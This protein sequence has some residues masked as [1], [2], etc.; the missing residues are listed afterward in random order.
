MMRDG[1]QGRYQG[2]Q[3]GW[4][5]KQL[6]SKAVHSKQEQG[7]EDNCIMVKEN[8]DFFVTVDNNIAH[9]KYLD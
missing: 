8:R 6:V 9:A 3:A 4:E 7:G 5:T 2:K 1:Y